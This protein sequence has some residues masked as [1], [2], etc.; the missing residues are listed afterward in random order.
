MGLLI[1]SVAFEFVCVCEKETFEE[2]CFVS[3]VTAPV[4]AGRSM[5]FHTSFCQDLGGVMCSRP[6]FIRMYHLHHTV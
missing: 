4:L 5:Q 2:V 6:V 1:C 3:P